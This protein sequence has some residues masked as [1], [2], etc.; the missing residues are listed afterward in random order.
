MAEEPF[1]LP[2]DPKA[3]YLAHKQE[4]DAAVQRVLESG[5]YILGREVTDFQQEFAAYHAVQDAVGTG[6]GTDALQLALRV[7]RIGEG[8]GVVTVSHTASATVAAIELAG[9]APVLVDID[10]R[11]F[12][13]DPNCVEETIRAQT[14]PR[15]KA[16]LPVHLYGHPVDMPAIME[17]AQRH[18]L[19][20]IEDCAQ[21]HGAAIGGRKTGCWGQMA[22]FSFYPTKNLG[23]LGDAGALLTDDRELAQRARPVFN[24]L[25]AGS[26]EVIY[27]SP[28]VQ[29]IPLFCKGLPPTYYTNAFLVGHDPAYLIDPGPTDPAEQRRLFAL[30]DARV[31]A[32]ARL[33]GVLLTHHHP[34]HM[35]AAD[36]IARRYGVPVIAH[37]WTAQA[38]AGKV[39]VDRTIDDGAVLDLG[40]APHGRPWRLE[41]IFTPG[42]APGHFCFYEATYRLLFVGDM[43]STMS[44]VV[45]TPPEGDIT[46]YLESLRRLQT[47]PARLLLPAHGSVSARPQMVLEECVNHRRKREEQLVQALAVSPRRVTE[48]A[49]EMYRGAPAEVMPYAEKQVLAGLLKLQREGRAVREEDSEASV[50]R[51]VRD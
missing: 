38:L 35:G 33:A 19:I 14:H 34:D 9:A 13:M 2:A 5:R 15:I 32:G 11:T 12:T 45:I 22:A 48:L 26:P 10:P 37:P 6:S 43:A 25:A 44:S 41:A 23:A 16:I 20:V 50:W 36:A 1:L 28:Q 4:I 46:E 7:C 31:S 49:Q 17:I 40:T 47:L 24:A 3:G 18:S 8:D 27:F 29:M 51:I 30:L 42:H 39:T 21:S